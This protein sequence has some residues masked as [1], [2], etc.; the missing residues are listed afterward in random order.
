M[1]NYRRSKSTKNQKTIIDDLNEYI[2]QNIKLIINSEAF[3]SLIYGTRCNLVKNG[4]LEEGMLYLNDSKENNLSFAIKRNDKII[5]IKI[6]TI[7]RITF[8]ESSNKIINYK[9]NKKG[10]VMQL[11]VGKNF[12]EFLFNTNDDLNKIIK[13]FYIYLTETVGV[14]DNIEAYINDL[15]KKYDK[16]FNNYIDKKEFEKL[17]EDLGLEDNNDLM[18]EI[19]ENHDGKIQYSEL[20][21]YYRSLTNGEEFKSIF[22]SY[23]KKIDD[24][25]LMSFYNLIE[26]FEDIQKES[27]N[28]FDVANI[29]IKFNRNITKNERE[30]LYKLLDTYYAKNNLEI[31]EEDLIEIEK[32][33]NYNLLSI[34]KKFH[35]T[36]TLK[37]FGIMLNSEINTVYNNLD[38]ELDLDNPLTDYFINSTHNTYLTGHQIHGKAKA[39]MYSRAVLNGYRLVELDCY[40]G[41]NDNIK[42]THGYTLVG[43]VNAKDILIELRNNSF[44]NSDLPVILCIENHLDQK[45]QK[46]LVDL[47]NDILKDL[48]IFPQNPIPEFLPNLN[49][50]KR[51]FLIKCGGPRISQDKVKEPIKRKKKRRKESINSNY[52][53]NHNILRKATVFYKTIVPEIKK[54][55]QDYLL[56]NQKETLLTKIIHNGE[57]ND[58]K[59]LDE[60]NE[61]EVII[62]TL[63]KIRGLNGT[64]FNFKEIEKMNYQPWEMVTLKCNKCLSYSSTFDK[65]V[66]MINFSKNT[67]IKVYPQ[68]FDSTNYNI[69]Q[70]W[71]LGANIAALNIQ[72]N[73]DDFTLYDKVFFLQNKNLGF[74]KKPDKLLFNSNEYESYNKPYFKISLNIISIFALSKLLDE[75][76]IKIR[77]GYSFVLKVYILGCREDEEKNTKYKFKLNDGFIFT[78]IQNNEEM[79]FDVYEKDLS[80]LMIKIEYDN[81]ILAR[82]C[83]PFCMMKEGYRR[84][85]IF[86]SFC[87]EF[88]ASCIIGLFKKIDYK[89]DIESN[90]DESEN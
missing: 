21:N 51:K 84:I 62:E 10:K 50:L 45:H 27:L 52:Y 85:P 47:F 22:K 61:N 66:K 55:N 13:G 25:E 81:K 18:Y 69:I 33:F 49:D 71:L 19:D 32:K 26:F 65:R 43:E 9:G 59:D 79:N 36:M 53:R 48:Y 29:I 30:S 3:D 24:E 6:D 64:K 73:L 70:W 89:Y 90:Y 82:S 7:D 54:K 88:P 76:G 20:L 23:S 74:V 77:K 63:D 16:D 15:W 56:L 78:R 57:N 58:D 17:K 42:V 14:E 5:N 8:N 40:N 41:D 60:E 39:S 28:L 34:R 12:M 11:L 75:T 37:E 38:D 4:K 67:L 2:E 46:V 86:D 72:A 44:K 31:Y 83:I 1:K 35:F 80:G 68:N 87:N